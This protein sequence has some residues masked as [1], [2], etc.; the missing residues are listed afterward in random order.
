M[1][2]RQ[3]TAQHHL[4]GN[5]APLCTTYKVGYSTQYYKCALTLLCTYN[6]PRPSKCKIRDSRFGI[7]DSRSQIRDARFEIRDS[8]SE[9]RD[10]RSEIRDPRFEIL[11]PR[12]EIR[13]SRSEIRDS[14]S[15]EHR[16]LFTI[17][18]NL[19]NRGGLVAWGV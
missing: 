14:R 10:P 9:I 19:V 16:I 15:P 6:R 1:T 17:K 3:Q 2:Q 12:C 8:G 18:K 7:R 5:L 4:E 13:D 11:D